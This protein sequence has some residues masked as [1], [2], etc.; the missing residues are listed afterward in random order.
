MY[1]WDG[2]NKG[3]HRIQLNPKLNT[4]AFSVIS[5]VYRHTDIIDLVIMGIEPLQ[6]PNY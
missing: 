2:P 6:P 5:K 4:L 3:F 1:K